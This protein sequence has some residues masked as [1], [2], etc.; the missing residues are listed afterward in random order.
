MCARQT[1]LHGSNA[2][3]DTPEAGV[4]REIYL[5]YSSLVG[6][7]VLDEAGNQVGHIHDAKIDPDDLAITAYGLV[8]TG[9]RH[10]LGLQSEIRPSEVSWSRELTL[11]KPRGPGAAN[12][13]VTVVGQSQ[14]RL[15][16][17]AGPSADE[18][19][20]HESQGD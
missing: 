15:D 6:L 1:L 2:S 10:W 16:A 4:D 9:W 17:P 5:N 20:N 14:Q 3:Q 7:Q 18:P 11:I 13:T 12:T 8:D 19:Q